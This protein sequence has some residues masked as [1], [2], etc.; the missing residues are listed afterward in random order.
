MMT[1]LYE[2]TMTMLLPLW[3]CSSKGLK[4]PGGRMLKNKK[5]NL[6]A[7]QYTYIYL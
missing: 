3:D 5:F 1:D 2:L 6:D 4:L 7:L